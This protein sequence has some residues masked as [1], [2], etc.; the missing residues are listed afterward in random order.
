MKLRWT[1]IAKNELAET[2]FHIAENSIEAAVN[3]Q[4]KISDAVDNLVAYPHR[5]RQGRRNNTRELVI[6]G[7]PW[8]IV[9]RVSDEEIIIL[10]MLHGAQEYP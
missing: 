6:P 8:L 3:V 5:G 1:S 7:L 4:T 10:R 9:Y 2:V